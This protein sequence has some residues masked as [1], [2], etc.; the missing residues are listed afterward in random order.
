MTKEQALQVLDQATE[1]ATSKGC[2][3]KADILT[4][5]TALQTIKEV[6]DVG[7]GEAK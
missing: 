7:V 3:T 2:Y 6:I 1:L 5:Q 4:I